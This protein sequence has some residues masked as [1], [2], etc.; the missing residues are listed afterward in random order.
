MSS[1]K[2]HYLR[3]REK[4]VT[5]PLSEDEIIK[6]CIRAGGDVYCLICNKKY[7][8]HPLVENCLD[9]DG[10]TFLNVICDGMIVKL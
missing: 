4:L 9:Q 3:Q 10:R 7:Y 1:D 5:L 8:D 2:L 6:K